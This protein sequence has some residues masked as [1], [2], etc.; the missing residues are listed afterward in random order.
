MMD[1]I[2]K[3]AYLPLLSVL[4]YPRSTNLSSIILWTKS[5]SKMKEILTV[6]NIITHNASFSI[7]EN[8][9]IDC[10]IIIAGWCK[11]N[12]SS[13]KPY[14]AN[15][16]SMFPT[17]L[18][19]YTMW[20]RCYYYL[21]VYGRWLL[22]NTVRGVTF[23]TTETCRTEREREREREALLQARKFLDW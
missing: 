2:I 7:H 10:H 23:C 22:I 5:S 19:A 8:S 1:G 20:S 4:I 13:T 3:Q 6:V 14:R 11:K 16:S 15:N 17:Y 21:E 9:I 18:K 12:L